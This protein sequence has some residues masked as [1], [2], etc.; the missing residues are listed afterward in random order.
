MTDSGRWLKTA[1]QILLT[2]S[3]LLIICSMWQADTYAA[4]RKIKTY[5]TGYDLVG[6]GMNGYTVRYRV[7]SYYRGRTSSYSKKHEVG[8][9]RNNSGSTATKSLTLSRSTTRTYSISVS[10]VIPQHVLQS[11]VSAT[12]GGSLSFNNTIS[13]SASASVPP[14][15]SRSVYLQYKYSKDKY[16]YVVQKQIRKLYGKWKNLGKQTVRYNTSTTKVPVLVL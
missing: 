5:Y 8:E 10:T 1:A 13:I 12:I 6:T 3:V 16:R 15:S 14:R 4:E 9:I 2:V 7:I 11:D